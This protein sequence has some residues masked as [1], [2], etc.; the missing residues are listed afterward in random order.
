[1]FTDRVTSWVSAASGDSVLLEFSC[2][3]GR[4]H[5]ATGRELDRKRFFVVLLGY[6]AGQLP[7]GYLPPQTA[8]GADVSMKHHSGLRELIRGFIERRM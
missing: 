1:M 8:G 5:Y 3:A 2:L 6:V 7:T 4:L